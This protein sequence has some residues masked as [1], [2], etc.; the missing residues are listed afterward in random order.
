MQCAL[1]QTKIIGMVFR[2]ILLIVVLRDAKKLILCVIA[3][4]FTICLGTIRSVVLTSIA[5]TIT[6]LICKLFYQIQP[7]RNA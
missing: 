7:C 1:D 3:L 6:K 2:G 5:S 4:A